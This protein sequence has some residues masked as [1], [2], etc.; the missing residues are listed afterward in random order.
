MEN[1]SIPG[2]RLGAA[3][4]FGARANQSRKTK[5]HVGR[6]LPGEGRAPRCLVPSAG[7]ARGVEP[8]RRGR[9]G[10]EDWGRGRGLQAQGWQLDPRA[11]RSVGL[12]ARAG[13]QGCGSRG[14]CPGEKT[15]PHAAHPPPR[16][17]PHSPA[18]PERPPPPEVQPI[19]APSPSPPLP[20][21][22]RQPG[23]LSSRWLRR[24]R[25]GRQ[26]GSRGWAS[27]ASA[28]ALSLDL[29]ICSKGTGGDWSL[30]FL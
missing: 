7:G 16:P 22:S 29:S 2:P 30:G 20:G 21:R 10:S 3:A 13:V 27:M 28:R 8:G 14:R 18:D 6:L 4:Q 12:G 19:R 25:Q 15:R 17:G 1:V 24:R 11:L 5:S 23:G 9:A 26:K